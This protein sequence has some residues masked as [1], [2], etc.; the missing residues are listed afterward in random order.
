[1]L[2]FTL[3]RSKLEYALVVWNSITST[4]SN[5]LERIKLKFA[6]VSFYRVPPHVPY[7]YTF[8]L[9]KLSLHS[10]RKRRPP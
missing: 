3:V 2:Y 4:D 8:A 7:G 5:K 9:Q 6:S 1:M 10:L